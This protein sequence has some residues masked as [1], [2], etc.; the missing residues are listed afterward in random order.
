MA[1]SNNKAWRFG[2]AATSY[3]LVVAG[4][5][6]DWDEVLASVEVYDIQKRSIRKG[7]SLQQPRAYFQIIPVGS[8]YPRLL[9]IGGRDSTST[10]STSEWW[11]E[12]E[13]SWQAGPELA[14]GR[15]NFAAVMAPP[16]LV[17]AEID[18]PAHSC[19]AGGDQMCNFTTS[20]SGICYVHTARYRH[21]L[22]N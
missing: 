4:G 13:D 6:T 18:L 8:K 12:E 10:L 17:C 2:C 5:V 9:A 21:Q 11:E 3:H 7:S 1:R 14:T 22:F 15:S 20:A 16:E 19:P